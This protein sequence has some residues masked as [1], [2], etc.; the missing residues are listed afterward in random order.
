[1]VGTIAVVRKY[2][3]FAYEERMRI[4]HLEVVD[5]HR[6]RANVDAGDAHR[7][8]PAFIVLDVKLPTS[9]QKLRGSPAAWRV[10]RMTTRHLDA[11]SVLQGERDDGLFAMREHHVGDALCA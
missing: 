2:T 9:L 5:R 10:D 6:L 11:V 4:R 3:V 7:H 8:Q 1:E